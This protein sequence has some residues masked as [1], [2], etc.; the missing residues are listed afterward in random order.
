[1]PEFLPSSYFDVLL[2]GVS[3]GLTGQFISVSG[4][5]IE[6]EFE[7]YVEGGSHFP[8]RFYKN[9]VPQTLVLEQGTL[10]DADSFYKWVDMVNRGI[11]APQSGLITLKDHT[12]VSKRS[13]YVLNAE[14]V[15][16]IGPDLN[17]NRSELAVTRIELVHN[18]CV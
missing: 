5:G 6:F 8:R 12:G 18:G 7:N 11:A 3:M 4:L 13:W 16:Y 14:I 9:V 1:M 2:G 15:K 17:S 10:S